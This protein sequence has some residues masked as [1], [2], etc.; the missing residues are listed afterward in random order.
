M[1]DIVKGSRFVIIYYISYVDQLFLESVHYS[2]RFKLNDNAS[3]SIT[4]DFSNSI[5]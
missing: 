4:R 5:C 2:S 1:M 3:R